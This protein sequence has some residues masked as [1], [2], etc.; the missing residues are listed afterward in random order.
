MYVF[1][2]L[3]AC[4]FVITFLP[5]V[6]PMASFSVLLLLFSIRTGCPLMH[7]HFISVIFLNLLFLQLTRLHFPFYLLSCKVPRSLA[8]SIF[9]S[10]D[11]CK[12]LIP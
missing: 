7:S 4:L 11:S 5:Y 3:S 1:C 12:S 6:E 9:H 8:Q 2:L 10:E